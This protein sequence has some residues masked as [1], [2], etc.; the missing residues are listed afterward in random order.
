MTR[1]FISYRR[2]DSKLMT[3]RIYDSLCSHYG[4]DMIFQDV[5][6]IPIGVDFRRFIQNE[7]LKSDLL[8]LVIGS[9]WTETLKSK[10]DRVD[11]FVR[12]E[13]ELALKFK[14]LIIPVTVDTTQMPNPDELPQDIR[15]ICYRNSIPIRPNPDF[16]NDMSRLIDGID[17]SVNLHDEILVSEKRQLADILTDD[18]RQRIWELC[19]GL[20]Q[21]WLSIDSIEYQERS[22]IRR[23][24]NIVIQTKNEPTILVYPKEDRVQ[25]SF[26]VYGNEDVTEFIDRNSYRKLLSRAFSNVIGFE[27][28]VDCDTNGIPF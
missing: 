24:I 8:L 9:N 14:K 12:L 10:L 7:I 17:K 5:G 11:D 19:V 18:H 21:L 28:N 27:V 13:I 16:A 2:S 4:V 3:D 20:L 1:I 26:S 6:D 22:D 15:D 23:F 25:L